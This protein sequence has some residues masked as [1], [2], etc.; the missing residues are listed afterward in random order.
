MR[1][2][3]RAGLAALLAGPG[4]AAAQEAWP[5]RPL[6]IIVPSA[7]GGAAD[8]TARLL[9][10]FLEPR[11]GQPVV[12]EN[13]PG[14]G[15]VIGTEATKNAAADGYTLLLS[16]NST[17]GA[18]PSLYR[19]LPYDPARD[20]AAVA[21]FGSY[22]MIAMVK[23]GS[24]LGSI[25]ALVAAAKARPGQIFFGYYSSSS[26]VPPELLKAATGIEIA[27]ASYRNITQILT[28]LAG[29]QFDFAF[30]DALSAAPALQGEALVPIAVTAPQ[31]LAR[32]PQVPTVAE[33]VPGFA[34]E[35]WFG[36]TAPAGTPAPV[37]ARLESLC[38]EAMADAAMREALERQGLTV[39]FL[40]ARD[41][42]SFMAADRRRWADW[43][44]IAGIQ[45][46]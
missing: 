15:G 41:F 31:R 4:Q 2:G 45:P 22:P 44:R 11:L 1:F 17:H 27:G 14:A 13:R 6:R 3:R 16:T 29:G 36:L 28:D 34:I 19:R 23:R 39:G 43:V 42:E 12:A 7:A 10:R 20:F 24:R 40:G 25:A 35:G 9:A 5:S 30:L 32:L 33:T 37:V 18:N 21:L 46:E 38:A 26:Q 8:F